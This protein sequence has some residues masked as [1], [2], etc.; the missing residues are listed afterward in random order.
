MSRLHLHVKRSRCTYTYKPSL[1]STNLT[2]FLST[3]SS[4][5]VLVD[6]PT[7]SHHV[8]SVSTISFTEI[9]H[10]ATKDV[11]GVWYAT[12]WPW[13]VLIPWSPD[14]V[15][16]HSSHLVILMFHIPIINSK[17]VHCHFLDPI[18]LNPP[19]YSCRFNPIILSIISS[20]FYTWFYFGFIFKTLKEN[21]ELFEKYS[22]VQL[23]L[24][25]SKFDPISI[26]SVPLN[27][28]K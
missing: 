16:S 25:H 2:P 11:I 10:D 26:R 6:A 9:N 8:L 7:T 21:P 24:V 23:T 13:H 1:Q 27:S 14:H 28:M 19:I 17:Q 22:C 4:H 3:F 20:L 5:S 12:P 18:A 15:I